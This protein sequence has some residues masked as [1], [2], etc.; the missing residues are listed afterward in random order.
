LQRLGLLKP[1]NIL[2]NDEGTK[3]EKEQT[4]PP[5]EFSLENSRVTL[6]TLCSNCKALNRFSLK[7]NINVLSAFGVDS[8]SREGSKISF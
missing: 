1:D 5:I 3:V 8:K 4:V 7:L 6:K 2:E